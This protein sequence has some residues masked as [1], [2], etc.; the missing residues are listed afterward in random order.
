VEIEFSKPFIKDYKKLPKVVQQN[1]D[2]KLS[3]LLQ[4]M[5]HPSLRVKKVMGYKDV[6]EGSIT[7]NYRFFFRYSENKYV[8]LRV[9]THNELLGS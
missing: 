8:L 3:I 2:K 9:G 7:M 4:N 1:L 6:W 5:Q